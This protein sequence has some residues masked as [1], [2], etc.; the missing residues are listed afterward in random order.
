MPA[1]LAESEQ[2]GGWHFHLGSG[3]TLRK[4]GLGGGKRPRSTWSEKR[5]P[6]PRR[7]QLTSSATALTLA[8]RP[9]IPYPGEAV[10][11][12]R[13]GST[14]H[15]T[16]AALAHAGSSRPGASKVAVATV[17]SR[18]L[19]PPAQLRSPG[20]GGVGG[21]E[22]FGPSL[23]EAARPW[24]AGAASAA[25]VAAR[26]AGLSP[27]WIWSPRAA[28][29]SLPRPPPSRQLPQPRRA[30]SSLLPRVYGFPG[31]EE[32]CLAAESPAP[33]SRS[34]SLGRRYSHRLPAAT[35]RPL[36]AAA[37]AEAAEG[38]AAAAR[39]RLAAPRPG[40]SPGSGEGGRRGKEEPR[41]ARRPAPRG[42]LPLLPARR[43]QNSESSLNL[44]GS[45]RI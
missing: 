1:Q 18:F 21:S 2:R 20:S 41:R 12:A 5:P 44:I 7:C 45:P 36:S 17:G 13:L 16:P 33:L 22:L 28:L 30:R 43:P 3:L 40:R 42:G 15:S 27:A 10:G 19:S 37:A 39:P 38:T 4:S 35:G 14:A 34:H 32:F 26:S 25:S 29:P 9:R 23:E 24:A 6:C 11:R 31:G 8:P